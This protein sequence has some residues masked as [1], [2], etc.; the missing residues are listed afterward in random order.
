MGIIKTIAV[1]DICK[2]HGS[3]FE[4][5]SLEQNLIEKRFMLSPHLENLMK[6]HIYL[7]LLIILLFTSCNPQMP[8]TDAQ[9]PLPPLTVTA[10]I[11]PTSGPI[12]VETPGAQFYAYGRPAGSISIPAR[13]DAGNF[14]LHAGSTITL[15]WADPPLDAARYDFT[16]LDASGI[17]IVIGTDIYPADGISTQWLV[18][19]NLPGHE[20]GGTAY[21]T[22]GQAV[23]FAYGG[24][25]YSGDIPPQDICTLSNNTVGVFPVHLEPNPS[26]Q[27]FAEL[28]PGLYVQVYERI[29]DDWYRID[30]SKLEIYSN[31]TLMCGESQTSPCRG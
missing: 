27:V 9:L 30:V 1:V 21:S 23:Y 16:M 28:T 31:T 14:F 10:L 4:N 11:S 29:S 25:V 15:T 22:E 6:Y 13:G 26:A 8:A 7:P 18:P 19:A 5:N 24:T 12:Q 17:P 3:L 20:I 2:I